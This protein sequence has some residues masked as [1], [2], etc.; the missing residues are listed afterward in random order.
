MV[1]QH[2]NKRQLSYWNSKN[3]VWVWVVKAPLQLTM[4]AVNATLP[5]FLQK[6]CK[7]APTFVAAAVLSCAMQ[8]TTSGVSIILY[9]Q[10]LFLQPPT[11]QFLLSPSNMSAPIIR[12]F[13]MFLS[14]TPVSV[15][16]LHYC[17]SPV[18]VAIFCQVLHSHLICRHL[19][20]IL[21]GV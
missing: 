19:W 14:L 7:T 5:T 13:L 21:W 16:H 3:S 17:A 10:S 4:S 12:A 20:A 15:N 18:P 6:R 11:L 1:T 2:Y 9:T 8:A